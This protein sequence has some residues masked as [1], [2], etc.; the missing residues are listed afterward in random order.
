MT[1]IEKVFD[2][3][4]QNNLINILSKYGVVDIYN[5][6][7]EIFFLITEATRSALVQAKDAEIAKLKEEADVCDRALALQGLLLKYAEE[8]IGGLEQERDLLARTVDGVLD[9]GGDYNDVLGGIK[10]ARRIVR[11]E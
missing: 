11:G 1:E 6:E 5:A 9:E 2:A 3:K 4:F 8:K 10:L 7:T